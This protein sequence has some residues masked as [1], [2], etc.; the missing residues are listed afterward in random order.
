MVYYK[1]N[2]IYIPQ[3]ALMQIAAHTEE[4]KARREKNHRSS[5][6]RSADLRNSGFRFNGYN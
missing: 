4:R 6:I 1:N 3:K 2:I 5:H